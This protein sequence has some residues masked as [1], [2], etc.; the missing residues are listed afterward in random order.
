MTTSKAT[1][2]TADGTRFLSTGKTSQRDWVVGFAL[3]V[4]LVVVLCAVFGSIIAPNADSQNL[5][6]RLTPPFW[7]AGGSWKHPL[8][9]DELGRSILQRLI[10]G[11]Q[12]TLIIGFLA[13]AVEVAIGAT[14]GLVAGYTGGFFERLVMRSADI[15]M[16]F[17][18]LLLLLLFLLTFGSN[19]RVL[20]LALGVNGWMIFGRL[21]H[22][23][24]R[25]LKSEPFVL[26]A[27]VA[28][29][30]SF[31]IIWQHIVPHV[32]SR[33]V[34]I[35]LL[36]VPRVILAAAGLSFLGLGVSSNQ[37]TWGMMIG[38]SRSIISVAY[39][40]SFFP[41]LAL[42]ITVSSLY[43]IAS[44]LEPKLDLLQLRRNTRVK[45]LSSQSESVVEGT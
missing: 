41:G 17:P 1:E 35:Y 9:T 38:D 8:G 12:I 44:W 36:E 29:M 2:N 34:A 4:F 27:K 39:W 42:V 15:Q 30:S 28:G 23:E 13:A 45:Q 14:L 26:A 31:Q 43:I 22:S 21:M 6:G 7:N 19:T 11:T 32:R 10:V 37:I 20:I 5:R 24:A 33:L 18:T 25:R 16:G 3:I 40:P